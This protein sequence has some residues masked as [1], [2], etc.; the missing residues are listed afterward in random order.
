MESH[1]YDVTVLGAGPGGYVAAIRAAQRGKRVAIVEKERLGG[2]CLNWG[3][4]PTKALLRI[5]ERREF[6]EEAARYGFEIGEVRVNWETVIRRSREAA[7]KL[8]NGVAFLM[9]KHKIRVF[10]G[11]GRFLAPNRI[12]VESSSG[13]CEIVTT[14]T[15]VATGGRPA[16]LPGVVA[17]GERIVTSKEAMVLP[18]RPARLA[19][20]G[21]GAIGLELAYFFAAFGTKVTIL[22]Y[23]PRALPTGDPEISTALER[24]FRR[25]KVDVVTSARVKS[26]ERRGEI[27]AVEYE[28]E[29]R[30][31]KIEADVVLVATGVRGNIEDLGL[32]RI[33]V[34]TKGPFIAVDR[35]LQTSVAGV[36]AIGDVIGPPALAHS[37]S[38]EGLH[39]VHHLCGE[40]PSPLDPTS[41]PA[42]IYCQPQVASVGLTEPEARESG[43]DVKIGR[44]PFSANGKAI[45][46]DE[47]EG[48]VKIIADA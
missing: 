22:E 8:A 9:R 16:L 18:S 13:S 19:V 48:F 6:L 47:P 44:F 24:A 42:C 35:D 41:I 32:E 12:G 1:S 25:R 3:C 45:A 27:A 39:A 4:I 10:S 36:Y 20:I 33:G 30:S 2:V 26:V 21:A 11:H 7:E 15:I 37:A 34:R 5:A 40:D 43:R 23:A 46:V 17:D 28:V 29:G 38:F 14:N 31:E